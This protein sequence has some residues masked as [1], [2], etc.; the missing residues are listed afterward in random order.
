MGCIP[1]EQ[2][3]HLVCQMETV[4]EVYQR[5]QDPR[6]PVVCMDETS[7]QC[8]KDVRESIEAKPGETQRYD[9]EYERNGVGHLLFGKKYRL[10]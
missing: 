10:G 7:K 4:L 6:Y 2:D 3:S 9:G 8:V 1:P 5:S